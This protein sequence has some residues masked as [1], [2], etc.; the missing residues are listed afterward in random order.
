[1]STRLTN[2]LRDTIASRVTDHAFAEKR[3]ALGV[4]RVDLFNRTL[5]HLHGATVLTKVARMPEHWFVMQ[6]IVRVNIGGWQ[7]SLTV[8]DAHA[9]RVPM[10]YPDGSRIGDSRP[11]TDEDLAKA[12]KD[13][14]LDE[15]K[16]RDESRVLR[17]SLHGILASCRTVEKFLELMPST[18]DAIG[19]LALA[20]QASNSIVVSVK[21]VENMI[22]AAQG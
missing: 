9:V 17:S 16:V 14:A 7:V 13:F 8:P 20:S 22:A 15:A 12:L 5:R 6:H 21:A 2:D 4:R 10:A 11:V 1:M 3:A 18:R 19:S